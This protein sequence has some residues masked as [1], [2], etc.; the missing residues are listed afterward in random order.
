MKDRIRCIKIFLLLLFFGWSGVTMG[1]PAKRGVCHK[2]LPD[3]TTLSIRMYGDE[4]FHYLTTLDG[5][6]IAQK[7]DGFYYYVDFSSTGARVLSDV[8]VNDYGRRDALETTFLRKRS[9]GIPASFRARAKM[10]NAER[11]R[12]DIQKVFVAKGSPKA[13]VVLVEFEDV[14]FQTSSPQQAF[15][16]LLNQKGYSANGGIGSVRDYYRDNSYGQFDPEFVVVGPYNLGKPMAYYGKNDAYGNDVRMEDFVKDA[17]QKVVDNGVSLK[18]F[19]TDGDGILDNVF[20]YY[21]GY[22]EAELGPDESIWPHRASIVLYH[23]TVDGMILADY[24]CTSEL[25]GNSGNR[26]AGIGTFCHEFGHVVGLMD[27]Y[28]TDYDENGEG[29][30]LYELSLMSSGNYSNGG[31][32]PP[33]LTAVERMMA[34][35]LEPEELTRAGSYNL[36][37]I[38]ENKAYFYTTDTDGE[39]F[40]LEYRDQKGWDAFI[41][42]AGLLIYQV[43]RSDNWVNGVKAKERWFQ[44]T[45]NC[46]KAHPCMRIIPANGVVEA[47][48]SSPGMFYPGSL[49]KTE[50]QPK[51]WSG[52]ELGKGLSNISQR[53][54]E[55]SFDFYLAESV[56]LTG[57]VTDMKGELLSGV[58]IVLKAV[59]EVVKSTVPFVEYARSAQGGNFETITDSRGNYTIKNLPA[60]KYVVEAEKE[61][62]APFSTVKDMI[63][64]DSRLDIELQT[65][66]EERAM[67]L[68]QNKDEV[69]IGSIHN[70]SGAGPFYVVHHWTAE[71]LKEYENCSLKWVDLDVSKAAGLELKVWFDD[72]CVLTKSLEHFVY[73]RL[74]R[75]YLE[76]AAVVIP[77]GKTLKVGVRATGE[78]N[79]IEI[80][81]TLSRSPQGGMLSINGTSW[82]TQERC[83]ILSAWLLES[84]WSTGVELDQ[85]EVTVGILDTVRL[86]AKVLPENVTNNAVVWSSSDEQIVKVTEKGEVIGLTEGVATVT[87]TAADGK[88]KITCSVTVVQDF[89]QL[90]DFMIGQREVRLVWEDNKEILNWKVRYKQQKDNNFRVLESDTTFCIINQLIPGMAYDV[91]LVAQSGDVETGV[92]VSRSFTTEN[93]QEEVASLAG[94]RTDWCEGDRYWP[95]VTNIQKD[96]RRVVWKLDGKT[97]VP[98]RDLILPAGTHVLRAE[99]T[100]NDGV[101]E[102]LVRKINV[103]PKAKKDVK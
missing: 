49:S 58:R 69:I 9:K 37:P 47:S 81:I 5:Y 102:I 7:E 98:T 38:S 25:Q 10:Q 30:G 6:V 46:I 77:A 59:E 54:N 61:G 1:I 39:I 91:E 82:E 17:C 101:T 2:V 53:G 29:P 33:C 16:D 95:V 34:G 45:I 41:K 72:A 22:N 64:T 51:P 66:A 19:D 15:N 71:E 14:K 83:M 89:V 28:D 48:F 42:G 67:K 99:V 4:R 21:A 57:V 85:K 60:G 20:I 13:L 103:Q 44:N 43:D 100:T 76:D 84:V 70:A 56:G 75:I 52:I 86:S 63:L 32:T 24:A 97:F 31:C 78:T 93:I 12:K 55:I 35:W 3:G 50:A 96:V 90:K 87:A 65:P 8:R 23:H 62:F 11:E 40:I 73:G 27:A 68:S 36:V 74:N 80:P 79:E 18:Q 94:I 88:S 92:L 26:M